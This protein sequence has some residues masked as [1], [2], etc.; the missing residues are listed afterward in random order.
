MVPFEETPFY[1]KVACLAACIEIAHNAS[2]LQDDIID[3]ADSRRS[4]KAAHKV[5][6]P[7][8]SIF[9]SDFMISRA[10][11]ML[12]EIFPESVHMSQLFS[13]VLCNLVFGELIQAKR[14]MGS[15]DKISEVGEDKVRF[16][17]SAAYFDSYIAKTYYK[18][19]S[20]ISLG[21]R[22]MAVMMNFDD[23]EAHRS[24]FNF[25]AHLGIA[26]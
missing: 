13:T 23:C 16:F 5:F 19:A 3:H 6:G 8:T 1:E 2:L 22:G 4:T 21:C 17:D 9:A 26:F 14:D 11:R 7:A 12:T 10:S 20:M 25:G 24:L 15:A 18:T